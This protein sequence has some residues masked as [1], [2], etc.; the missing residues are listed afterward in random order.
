ME[1]NTDEEIETH[2][3]SEYNDTIKFTFLHKIREV[4]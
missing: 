3:D 4:G 1:G 2:A